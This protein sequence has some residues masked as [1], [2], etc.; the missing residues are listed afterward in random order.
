M[1]IYNNIL[2]CKSDSNF[3]LVGDQQ[4]QLSLIKS[5]NYTS[6]QFINNSTDFLGQVNEEYENPVK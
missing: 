6:I 4:K 3:A 5:S 2:I 1:I